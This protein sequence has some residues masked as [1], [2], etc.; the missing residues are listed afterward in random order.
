M[1]RALTLR[2]PLKVALPLMI[3]LLVFISTGTILLITA[4]RAD[5]VIF[6]LAEQNLGQIH[7]RINDH[8][9][10]YFSV[11]ER[12]SAIN[13]D[14]L[15]SDNRNL[16][17]LASLTRIFH[18]Q[19]R[20]AGTLSSMIWGDRDG[21]TLFVARYPGDHDTYVGIQLKDEPEVKEYRIGADS[22]VESEPH[23]S[24]A[25]DPHARP[26]YEAGVKA[27]QPAW[28]DIYTWAARA[29]V[30]GVPHV[31]PVRNSAGEFLGVF[32]SEFTLHN[33]SHFLHS[34]KIG[35][36]GMVYI[37]DGQGLLVAASSD[38]AVVDATTGK[39]RQARASDDPLI[40]ASAAY[41][42]GHSVEATASGGPFA[43][44][45][46]LN[47]QDVMLMATPFERSGQLHWQVATLVPTD[48]F[49]A[50]LRTG[51]R[52]AILFA[53][54]TVLVALALGIML[55][56][57]VARP[58]VD[59]SQ[60]VRRIGQGKLDEV[61][62]LGQFPEFMRLSLALNGMVEKLRE[63]LKLRESLALATE[64][65]QR[66]LPP[67]VP[68]YPGLEVAARSFYCEETGGDYYDYLKI[69]G[70]PPEAAAI[71]IGDVA[72]HGIASAMVMASARAVLRSRCHDARS[73]AELL[74]H[75]NAQIT[76]DSSSGRF[77]TM[78]LMAV[79]PVT[80]ELKWASAGHREPLVLDPDTGEFLPLS[81][82]GIPLGVTADATYEDY[83]YA[84]L[85]TGQIMLVATDGLW[86]A[87]NP[88]GEHFGLDRLKKIMRERSHH[89]ANDI[90]SSITMSLL[91]FFGG[92]PQVDD[93][94]FVIVKV[95]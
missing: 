70:M 94:S 35:K 28:A 34:L 37:I 82:A 45:V 22:R 85:R 50:E 25:Y 75:M 31:T 36:T 12:I 57:Y 92:E 86:E 66:L 3:S 26:W 13:R 14:L 90:C 81:G 88:A 93:I 78:L 49:L 5:S 44:R 48:D 41:L 89:D 17:D 47:D 43:R 87:A 33:I 29:P 65:Q 72:G 95:A 42:V 39:R 80:R 20:G 79:N 53:V 7:E 11:A 18:G 6:A 51:R 91:T 52:T 77:M 24:Y 63:R 4:F 73:L 30:L 40:A 71:A 84:G 83:S 56:L 32:A 46:Q 76:E 38:T 68:S 58:I 8:L 27:G 9:E 23:N 15:G 16:E 59:L 19:F 62:F 55:A 60:H 54:A 2:T 69:G 67:K 1:F 64:V 10:S 21:R 61:I 74:G